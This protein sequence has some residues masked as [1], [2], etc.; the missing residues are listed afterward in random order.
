MRKER[1][2]INTNIRLNLCDEQD[3]QAWEYLQTMDREKYKS[4]TRAVVV[5]L[6]DYFSREYR[7]EAD[8]YLETREKEDAFQE[9]VETAIRDGVK[10]SVPMAMAKNLRNI[11]LGA[12]I[13]GIYRQDVYEIPPDAIR[14]LIINAMV[15][16]SY[17]DHGT[18]QVA[19]YDNRLE[20]TS[21]GKLPM[22]QT[23]ERMK[24][25][26][27]KIR[28]EALAHAFAYMNLIEHWGS[29]IP[30]II[31]KVKAA[32]LRELEFIGGEVD[33]RINIYRDQVATNN[34]MINANGTKNG[35]N[36]VK[37]G[38]DDGTNSAEVPLNKE[39]TQIEK[40]LQIIEKN[41]SATQAYY[42]EKMGISKRTISR[43]FASLQEKG[44][45]VQGGT[46][47][48]ANWKIIR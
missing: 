44:R 34:A 22:G 41:P 48:K 26:Y 11:H 23:M 19:V 18:I 3:R 36:G 29:G 16:R 43:M 15:H 17:L 46:K 9:R 28:N 38:V 20:I 10:E 25:G 45:L 12:T 14:E 24:E 2:I 30:R 5:A 8:P 42:A 4:Y 27:S 31:D 13:V 40:L 32:G 33:L 39:Q 1:K 21:P 6:N 47:R 7:N 37:C 35:A